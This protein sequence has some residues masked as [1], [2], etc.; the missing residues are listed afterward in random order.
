MAAA[1]A[2]ARSGTSLDAKP[3]LQSALAGLGTS[4]S[5]PTL[6]GSAAALT[7][8]LPG[9]SFQ[10]LMKFLKP[11]NQENPDSVG[12][13]ELFAKYGPCDEDG[14]LRGGVGGAHVHTDIEIKEMIKH[15]CREALYGK[16][17]K[18][19]KTV[20]VIVNTLMPT[21]MNEKYTER[22][23][24][25]L[26]RNVPRNEYGRMDFTSLQDLVFESQSQRL[27]LLVKRAQDGKP[28]APP[29]E[30]PQKVPFQ[31]KT[32][33]TMLS[34]G[35]KKSATSVSL[36]DSLEAHQHNRIHQLSTLRFKGS[37]DKHQFK[38]MCKTGA[39]SN[40]MDAL[41]VSKKL[42]A[43]STLCGSLEDQSMTEELRQNVMLCRGLGPLHDRWD[44]YCALRRVGRSSYVNA[45]NTYRFNAAMDEGTSNKHPGCSSLLAASA[46]GSSA[47]AILGAS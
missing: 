47:A 40:S 36:E 13:L 18:D 15:N 45:R 16:F 27:Q 8:P 1:A 46:G 3:A 6:A 33:A 9:V 19:R 17:K 35:A 41:H 44:R 20:E 30:R 26:L 28:I 2:T 24:R 12:R 11:S 23:I 7:R 37:V 5:M 10:A 43:Y 32:A 4:K 21:A 31:S 42:N 39:G 34:L 25:Q 14:K 38:E 22:Q 29:V